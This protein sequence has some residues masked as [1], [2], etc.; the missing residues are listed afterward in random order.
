MLSRV[1]ESDDVQVRRLGPRDRELA[2]VTFDLLA[3]V[4]GEKHDR[5]TDAYLDELLGRPWFLV[6][7]ATDGG[8]AVGGLTAHVLPMTAC[9]GAEVF[10]YDVAVVDDYQRRG[11]GRRLL[12]AVRDEASRLGT[13]SVFVL[14]DNEDAGALAFYRTLGGVASGVTLFGFDPT[15]S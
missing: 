11:V 15:E 7:A 8:Q 5:L 14:A 13:S 4:F 9:E 3:D 1:T 12:A 2:R 10:I 6:L